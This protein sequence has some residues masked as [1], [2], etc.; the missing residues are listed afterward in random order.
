MV[1]LIKGPIVLKR[2]S[3]A[4]DRPFTSCF[5]DKEGDGMI[6]WLRAGVVAG[7]TMIGLTLAGPA[8]AAVAPTL[9]VTAKTGAAQ[10]VTINGSVE[11]TSDP[12]AR[13]QIY[14]PT[15]FDVNAP[16]GGTTVGSATMRG[17]AKEIDRSSEQTY[18]GSIVA[19]SPT[20]PAVAYE[21]TN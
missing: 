9:A 18:R 5:P 12:I 3:D 21:N 8:L 1:A 13:I 17:I 7:A 11:S 15:G 10:N 16:A 14:L 20:D 6:T 4:P 19:I 2:A